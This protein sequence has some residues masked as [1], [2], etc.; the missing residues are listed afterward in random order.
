MNQQ[1][2]DTSDL[3]L[4]AGILP[5]TFLNNNKPLLLFQKL[6]KGRKK[7]LLV[8]FGGKVEEEE[9]IKIFCSQAEEEEKNKSDFSGKENKSL[10]QNL[11]NDDNNI[12]YKENIINLARETKTD[13]Y[14]KIA[15][16]E[17]N[18]ETG[19]L[20]EFEGELNESEREKKKG[21]IENKKDFIL[22]NLEKNWGIHFE[23]EL[24]KD[25]KVILEDEVIKSKELV[26]KSEEDYQFVEENQQK[27]KLYRSFKTNTNGVY[28]MYLL[29]I[30]Y[31]DPNLLNE[32]YEN[33]FEKKREFEWIELET[34]LSKK[35]IIPL[36]P[37]IEKAENPFEILS[38]I[39]L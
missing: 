21:E 30:R 37:R 31:F 11:E 13:Y 18:E 3:K 27:N 2:D 6:S 35:N 23:K 38:Q 16:R 28:F 14:L 34:V 36:H 26:R 4:G 15:I 17:F 12:L 5:F 22:T 7:G 33:F 20:L 32:I 10:S 25:K 24:K 19:G 39:R 9:K 29:P 8:D 1:F